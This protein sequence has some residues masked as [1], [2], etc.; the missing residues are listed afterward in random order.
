[1]I[2]LHSIRLFLGKIIP[3]T[4]VMVTNMFVKIYKA[5]KYITELNLGLNYL[6][7]S[8]SSHIANFT[9][10]EKL[11]LHNNKLTGNLPVEFKQLKNLKTLNLNTNNLSGNFPSFIGELSNLRKIDISNNEFSG[12][13]PDSMNSLNFL[14]SFCA[15]YNLIS[16]GLTDFFSNTPN[17]TILDLSLNKIGGKIPKSIS[18]L[19]N[20]TELYLNDNQL[21]GSLPNSFVDLENLET[22]NINNNKGLTGK[23]PEMP[24]YLKTC[25][26]KDT[27]L[28]VT[29]HANCGLDQV[30]ICKVDTKTVVI[31]VIASII[32]FVFIL[33]II[34]ILISKARKRSHKE[35][36]SDQELLVGD[37]IGDNDN[38]EEG[39][40][41]QL[42]EPNDNRRYVEVDED[43][44]FDPK[45]MNKFIN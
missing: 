37:D 31:I 32:G 16:G 45:N 23:V 35:K 39:E 7:G 9:N 10:L 43:Y 44:I 24:K 26:Y 20:L 34:K 38:M 11:D 6:S 29:E 8:I 1:M 33:W 2:I 25:N 17:L 21:E 22:L 40:F 42:R 13:L 5:K 14:E 36:Q 27:N 41:I 19:T 18:E 30:P 28:C 3:W 4:V 15:R 12:N